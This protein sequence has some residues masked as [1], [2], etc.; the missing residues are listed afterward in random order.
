MKVAKDHGGAGWGG[1]GGRQSYDL[2]SRDA[3]L[4]GSENSSYEP[5]SCLGGHE[6]GLAPPKRL[7]VFFV[8][9]VFFN[10]CSQLLMITRIN[11]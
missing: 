5:V 1:G 7:L 8:V 3:E 10:K 4:K 11:P 6:V 9:V 2:V